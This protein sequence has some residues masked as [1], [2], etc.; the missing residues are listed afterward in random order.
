MTQGESPYGQFNF[1]VDIGSGNVA[2][3]SEISGLDSALTASEYRA[4][5]ET[6]D[7]ARKMPSV[8]KVDNVTL[9]RGIVNSA[10]F[11]AWINSSQ[12]AGDQSKRSVRVTLVDKAG[13]PVTKWVLSG[14]I[15]L[16]HTGPTM[17][18]KGNDVAMETLVLSCEG[19]TAE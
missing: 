2:S 1:L 11:F 12:K 7:P 8:H 9:K 19:C 4:G 10:D 16:K 15:P 18:G 14:A 5:N 17:A 6:K 3:F 13:N